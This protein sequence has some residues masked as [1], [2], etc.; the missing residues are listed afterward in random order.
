MAELNLSSIAS[1]LSGSGISTIAKTVGAEESNVQSAI[2]AALPALISGM[3]K[4][5][6]TESGASSLA[7]ALSDHSG[8]ST[9]NIASFLNNVDLSDGSKIVSHILGSSNTSTTN[10]IAKQSGLSSSKVSQILSMIAPL[11]L[12]L[13]GKKNTNGDSSSAGLGSLLGSILGSSSDLGGLASAA[14]GLFGGSSN[15]SSSKKDG[16][17]LDGILK[18]FK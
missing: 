6:S 14:S 17:L 12:S 1:L 3:Q 7:K 15:K 13:I 11:L 5:V 18:I 8:D 9:S 10:A 4:N 16:G 2:G